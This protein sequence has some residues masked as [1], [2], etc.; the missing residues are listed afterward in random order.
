M[1]DGIPIWD[2]DADYWYGGNYYPD[3]YWNILTISNLKINY[4]TA[5]FYWTWDKNF[6]SSPHEYKII[7]KKIE[8]HWRIEYLEGFRYFGSVEHYDNY[9]KERK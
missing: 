9:M 2:L 7:A 8:N 4:S 1:N 5:S 3:D 6:T